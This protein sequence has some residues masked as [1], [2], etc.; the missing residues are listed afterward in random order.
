MKTP[1]GY[2][3]IC[4]FSRQLHACV[5]QCPVRVDL[6][7]YFFL[8]VLLQEPEPKP[9]PEPEPRA[10]IRFRFRFFLGQNDTVPAVQVP[11]H[12]TSIELILCPVGG[13]PISFS[14]IYFSCVNR[15]TGV[16]TWRKHHTPSPAPPPCC[17]DS[18]CSSTGGGVEKGGR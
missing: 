10:R 6:V 14:S 1:A 8:T 13:W 15:I 17:I 12:Y 18:S 2:R 11:Q 9:E 4:F 5:S 7:W 3:D 16:D